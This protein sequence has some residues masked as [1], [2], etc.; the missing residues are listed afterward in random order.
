MATHFLLYLN[1]DTFLD[2][3]G[4]Q[5]AEELRK[6]R[7]ANFNVIMAHEND[8]ARGGCEFVRF[9]SVTPQDLISGGLYK[10][11]AFACY[12]GEHRATSMALL[13]KAL[14]AVPMTG[15]LTA[16]FHSLA[17][18]SLTQVPR[19]VSRS[20]TR[21]VTRRVASMVT[22]SRA[23]SLLAIRRRWPRAVAAASEVAARNVEVVPPSRQR[24][25]DEPVPAIN[26]VSSSTILTV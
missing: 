2:S 22:K 24:E 21:G 7:A 12:P 6:A 23:P 26:V 17:D 25:A 14:G 15:I 20:A 4:K 19:S 5:L 1:F 13:A 10:A 18:A 8:P 3:P 9:F 11:L 16:E